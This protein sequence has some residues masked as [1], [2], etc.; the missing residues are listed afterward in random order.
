M[1][2]KQIP[3]RMAL[4]LAIAALASGCSRETAAPSTDTSAVAPGAGAD[5]HAEDAH[6]SEAH[7]ASHPQAAATDFP[8]PANHVAWTPDAPLLE[9]MS[10][11][12]TALDA[13]EAQPDK[14][15]VLARADAVDAAVKFMFDN[16]KLA[17]EPDVALHAVLAR[18]MAGSQALHANPADF[19][20][21]HD[22]H[23]AMQNYQHLFNDPN[24]VGSTPQ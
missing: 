3:A 21:V 13:L 4:A 12:R 23:A 19:T 10:R 14:V 7:D 9:G 22:M 6:A 8:V 1:K 11:V 18:L 16:C 20:P 15:A 17:P 24:S 5:A 2:L